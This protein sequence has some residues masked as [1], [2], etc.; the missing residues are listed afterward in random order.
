VIF[1]VGAVFHQEGFNGGSFLNWYVISAIG[2]SI[3][4]LALYIN[5]E[6]KRS[7]SAFVPEEVNQ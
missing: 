3:F 6:I 5:M 7:A 4:M 2:I 1:L